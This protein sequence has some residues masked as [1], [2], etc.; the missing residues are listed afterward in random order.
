M[1]ANQASQP[2]KVHFGAQKI[3]IQFKNAISDCTPS[4]QLLFM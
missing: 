2:I 1:Q 3:L 4:T